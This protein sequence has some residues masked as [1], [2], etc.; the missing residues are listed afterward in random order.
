[1]SFCLWLYH[2]SIRTFKAFIPALASP[3]DDAAKQVLTKTEY[4]LYCQMDARDRDHAWQVLRALEKAYPDASDVLK[5]ATLLHD[6]G[7]STARFNVF[8]RIA[9][10][11][12]A[13]FVAAEPRL[14]G[15]R[16]A[17][18][19]NH[20]HAQYGADMIRAAGGDNAVAAIVAQHHQPDAVATDAW[21]LWQIE[22]T[23]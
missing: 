18:Q 23:F 2:V 5:R 16:G 15:L 13:P 22:R 8:E 10:H 17:W 14:T 1:M 20:H 3:D 4:R 11:V 12:Y 7:K 6:V 9:V 19:R 21:R